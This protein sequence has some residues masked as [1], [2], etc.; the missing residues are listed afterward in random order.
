MTLTV[1]WRLDAVMPSVVLKWERSS[2]LFGWFFFVFR[3]TWEDFITSVSVKVRCVMS[4]HPSDY[5]MHCRHL[6]WKKMLAI[7]RTV[8][9][10]VN[11]VRKQPWFTLRK[12]LCENVNWIEILIPIAST[13][14][15]WQVS[16]EEVTCKAFKNY[17]FVTWESSPWLCFC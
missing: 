6:T 14:F 3:E 9:E 4:W 10:F 1:R 15:F 11:T 16:F 17:F 5:F 13:S 12:T 2:K 8:V 7:F